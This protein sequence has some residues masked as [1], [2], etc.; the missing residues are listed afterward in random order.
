MNTTKRKHEK[1]HL[2]RPPI[3]LVT[4][5]I[6]DLSPQILP[7]ASTYRYFMTTWFISGDFLGL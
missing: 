6:I 2:R 4:K 5:D 1:Q 7:A 3:P